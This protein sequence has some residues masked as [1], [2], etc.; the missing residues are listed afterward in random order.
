MQ[1]DNL[2]K[3]LILDMDGVLWRESEPIGNLA[4]VF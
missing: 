4:R 3:A 1:P 2:I